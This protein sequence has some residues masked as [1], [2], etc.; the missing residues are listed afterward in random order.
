MS[1]L[2]LQR[3]IS[4]IAFAI[5]LAAIAVALSAWRVPGGTGRL[6]LDLRVIVSNSG[7]LAASPTGPFVSATGLEP[8]SVAAGYTALRNETGVSLDVRVRALPNNRGAD[9]TLWVELRGGTTRLY[10]GPLGGLRDTSSA[11]ARLRPGAKLR[12]AVRAW[13]PASAGASYRGRIVDVPLALVAR[14]AK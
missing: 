8:G 10:R 13:I 2:T 6:G 3:L 1:K 14:R 4:M 7:E 9:R 5:G 12:L 11:G